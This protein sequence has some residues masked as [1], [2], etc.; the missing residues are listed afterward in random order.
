MTPD[1]RYPVNQ[2]LYGLTYSSDIDEEIV[3]FNASS[4]V[5][6]T[7]LNLGPEVYSRAIRQALASG[8][9]LDS[10]SLL[11][12]FDQAQLTDFLRAVSA[13]L[14]QLRPWPQPE[15]R[16]L[17]PQA[18]AG[19]GDAVPVAE[20]DASVVRRTRRKTRN[21]SHPATTLQTCSISSCR[22]SAA[23]AERRP[24][25]GVKPALPQSQ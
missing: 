16:P 3:N 18:W 13:R 4:A 22:W 2:L 12:Q 11:P 20:L 19:F 24:P 7:T 23:A 15:V 9:H 17:A 10:L 1:W 8:E 25:G 14:D 21:L 5:D 6:Y